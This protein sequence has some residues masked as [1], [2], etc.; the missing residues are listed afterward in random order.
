M[1]SS[2]SLQARTNE[3]GR[4]DRRSPQLSV[5]WYLIGLVALFVAASVAGTV[6]GWRSARDDA[7]DRALE[8]TAFAAQLGARAIADDL[9]A[10]HA[11]VA[12]TAATPGLE[13]VFAGAPGCVLRFNPGNVFPNGHIDIV[14]A[15]GTVGCSSLP[16]AEAPGGYAGE[17]WL[18]DAVAGPVLVGP[19]VD[20][21]TGTGTIV[22]AAPVAGQGAVAGFFDT[23]TLGPGLAALLGG[24]RQLE[25]LVTDGATSLSRSVDAEQWDDVP[26]AGTSF[27]PAS[28]AVER[29]DVDGTPRY[30][31][32]AEVEGLGWT[33]FVGADRD[34]A[35]ADA[36][37]SFQ[38]S[39]AII[40]GGLLLCLL[41]ALV[42]YRQITRPIRRLSRAVRAA[43]QGDRSEVPDEGGAR[44]VVG[45]SDDFRQLLAS[46]ERELVERHAAE[47]ATTASEARYRALFAGHPLPM[48]LFDM[49]TRAVVEVNEAAVQRYGYSRSEFL[50]MTAE[51][52]PLGGDPSHEDA[53][54]PEASGPVAHRARHIA[55]DGSPIDVE[56]KTQVM[57]LGDRLVCLVSADDVTERDRLE[58]QLRQSQ[59][60]ESLGQLAGGVAHDFNNLLN[61]M[62]NYAGFV[63]GNA[64]AALVDDASDIRWQEVHDDATQVIRSVERAAALTRQL[65]AFARRDVVQPIVVQVPELVVGVQNLLRR[66]LGEDIDL[67]S[68][69]ADD[70]HP[71]LADPGQLEQILVNLA[72][73]ARDAMPDGGTLEIAVDNLDVDGDYTATHLVAPGPYLRIRVSDTGVGMDRETV[74]RAFEPF[75]TT[76]GVGSGTGLGLAT[77]Y[78]IVTQARGHA[79]I[80]SEPGLGTTVSLL[81]PATTAEVEPGSAPQPD[82]VV[83]GDETILV[84]EDRDD[85]RATTER[86]LTTRGYR[87]LTAADGPA[88][89]AVAE[90]ADHPIDLVLSDVILA[91]GLDGAQTA[92]RL[93]DVVPGAKVLFMSGYAQP[94]LSA[95]AAVPEG[96]PLIEKPFTATALLARVRAAL[97]DT[98]VTAP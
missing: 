29:R 88:A 56:V 20:V 30:Y 55:R 96:A 66:T 43:T 49:S 26:L 14:A 10:L 28:T 90:R 81:L 80:Y 59:R 85:L 15:D 22:D 62:L 32:R 89:I 71:V 58:A 67:R 93:A 17:T 41:A 69:L 25:F 84:V 21:R 16:D 53:V 3:P 68:N 52:V 61:V 91:G 37:S 11:N 50:A 19:I 42:A 23:T 9:A 97:D 57:P 51:S 13:A 82:S 98:T 87:V 7:R 64:A 75:F 65:L 24:P 92:A 8:D 38:R 79:E 74:D 2:T 54:E 4:H 94:I 5:H 72:V 31:A 45:L 83:G 47:E 95:R 36:A 48:W 40:G 18:A 34:A 12:A 70:A 39:A 6:Y 27:D 63:E 60:L 78:G 73:N 33:V 76:K 44:E 46:V 1:A 35:L 77:V 86:I